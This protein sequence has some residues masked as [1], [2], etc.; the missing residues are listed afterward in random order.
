MDRPSAAP[1]P[2]KL[3]CGSC[4]L[5]PSS[6]LASAFPA[7]LR[8]PASPGRARPPAHTPPNE[9]HRPSDQLSLLRPQRACRRLPAAPQHRST[10]SP[11]ALSS[12]LCSVVC[13]DLDLSAV[14]PK[15]CTAPAPPR[16][17]PPSPMLLH[18]SVAVHAGSTPGHTRCL[19]AILP[20]QQADPAPVHTLK[21]RRASA[22][23]A[24]MKR[25]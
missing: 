24:C 13:A 7:R 17:T 16:E 10:A 19:P 5:K 22:S 14:R 9:H 11:P 8:A 2:P 1:S 21:S 18:A 15:E 25:Q 4:L 12:A 3:A 20:V 6:R 23:P